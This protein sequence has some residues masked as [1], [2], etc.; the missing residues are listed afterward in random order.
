MHLGYWIQ[1]IL[2]KP[3]GVITDKKSRIK[4]RQNTLVSNIFVTIVILLPGNT[5]KSLI[6]VSRFTINKIFAVEKNEL[7]NSQSNQEKK[8]T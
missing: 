1:R 8:R 2:S 7:R 3:L 6:F 5:D 4:R